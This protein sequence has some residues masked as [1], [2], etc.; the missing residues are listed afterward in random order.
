VRGR[1]IRGSGIGLSLV[2]HIAVAH[3]GK[4]MLQSAENGGCTFTVTV[5]VKSPP[6]AATPEAA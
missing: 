3:G 5:P 2:R 4:V 1:P 6:D